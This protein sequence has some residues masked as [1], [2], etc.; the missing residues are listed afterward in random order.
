MRVR[1]Q[2]M[3]QQDRLRGLEVGLTGHDRGGVRGG[4]GGQCVDDLQHAVRD[5]TDRVAQPHPEQRGHLVV[6]GPSGPQAAAEFRSDPVD[7]APFEC[8]VHVLVGDDGAEAAVGDVRAEA[9]QPGQQSVALFLGEQSGPKQH[10]CMGFRR[11]D[12]VRRQHPVEVGRLAQRRKRIRGPALE[13]AAPQC[14]LVC[15][16]RIGAHL[17]PLTAWEVLVTGP[18]PAW[19]RSSTTGRAHARSPWPTT[20][21]SCRPRRRWPG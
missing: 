19:R 1:Q 3:R 21:R 13:P 20:G 14:A 11:G 18:G 8:A 12:V 4:L 16:A 17:S 10:A 5:T 9:V 15:C 7:Q 2:V 6:S